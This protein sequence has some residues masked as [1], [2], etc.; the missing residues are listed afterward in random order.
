MATCGPFSLRSRKLSRDDGGQVWLGSGL[1]V[2][3]LSDFFAVFFSVV[4]SP[5]P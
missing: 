5:K 4:C 2:N 3:R 1:R